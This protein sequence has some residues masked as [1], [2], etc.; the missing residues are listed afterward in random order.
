[1]HAVSHGDDGDRL[2]GRAVVA[3]VVVVVCPTCPTCPTA[4]YQTWDE[5]YTYCYRVAGTVGLMTLP[6]MGTAP[7][8]T[9][10]QVTPQ[11]HRRAW[12][13]RM[14][15]GGVSRTPLRGVWCCPGC[16]RAVSRVAS[17]FARRRATRRN[18][19]VSIGVS[20]DVSE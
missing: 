10:E 19:T 3:V 16:P 15:V 17:S 20:R 13:A 5:L 12:R 4:R 6:I 9:F 1:M 2:R 18:S 14:H 8:V 11:W 7:G